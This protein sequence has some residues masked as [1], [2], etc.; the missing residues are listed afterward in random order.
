MV[1]RLEIKEARGL[2]QCTA[3]GMLRR[4]PELLDASCPGFPMDK[5][6]TDKKRQVPRQCMTS[7]GLSDEKMQFHF[8]M[9]ENPIPR[10]HLEAPT[11]T[12]HHRHL[13]PPNG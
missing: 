2:F 10:R 11:A 6:Q 4:G 5:A 3:S 12:N 9:A 8:A 13:A 1:L 7:P